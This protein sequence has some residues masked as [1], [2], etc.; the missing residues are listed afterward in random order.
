MS[1]DMNRIMSLWDMIASLTGR[2]FAALA[3][4]GHMIPMLHDAV[5]RARHERDVFF[6][7]HMWRDIR[8]DLDEVV[9]ISTELELDATIQAALLAIG[10]CDRGTVHAGNVSLTRPNAERLYQTLHMIRINFTSQMQSRLILVVETRH[11]HFLTSD[12]PPF[13]RRVED[14]FPTV[15]EEVSEA[16]KCLALQRPTAVVFHL[17]RAMELAIQRMARALECGNPEHKAWGVILSDMNAKIQ[18]MP[19][20]R[21]RDE[22]SASLSHLYHVKQAWRNDTMHPKATYTETQADEV[23]RAVRSFMSHL[24]ELVAESDRPS[25]HIHGNPSDTPL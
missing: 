6:S 12:E 18:K 20:G 3:N 7:H 9:R 25:H 4:I 19:R 11:A 1:R 2:T 17:M 22:W 15:S 13:G 23:F 24:A 16:A 8:S 5:E 21:A 10:L 14:V